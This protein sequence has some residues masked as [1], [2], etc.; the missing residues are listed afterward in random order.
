MKKIKYKDIGKSILTP[1]IDNKKVRVVMDIIDSEE[2]T[3]KFINADELRRIADY[4][5]SQID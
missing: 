1:E 4:L 3:T 5:D 2:Q